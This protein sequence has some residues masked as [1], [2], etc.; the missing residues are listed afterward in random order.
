MADQDL[1]LGRDAGEVR[2][3]IIAIIAAVLAHVAL[4]TVT[5]I[6]GILSKAPEPGPI[7][8]ELE[9]GT[10][11]A[12]DRQGPIAA[13]GPA[14][15][16]AETIPEASTQVPRTGGGAAPAA[17][18]A[19][20]S[21][22]VI[23]TPK[24][25]DQTT[26]PSIS[27]PAFRTSGSSAAPPQSTTAPLVSQG[28]PTDVPALTAPPASQP[29]GGTGSTAVNAPARGVEVSGQS[30]TGGQLDLGS[31][32]SALQG[33]RSGAGGQGGSGS[34]GQSQGVAGQGGSGQ[35]GGGGGSGGTGASAIQWDT[36]SAARNRQPLYLPDPKIPAWVAKQGFTLRVTISFILSPEG[37]VSSANIE[38]SSGYGDVD[39]AV[40]EAV[41]FWRFT[42]DDAAAPLRGTRSFLFQL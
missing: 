38:R 15:A 11:P 25:A 36:P 32:D 7:F 23:P 27:G 10:L 42:A 6:A 18:R 5:M 24:G 22:F 2:R 35:T 13:A 33:A 9:S 12:G 21:D 28:S 1:V 4:V 31:L 40:L 16:S 29:S 3:H 19:P 14:A 20:S 39:A 8:L 37:V 41:R 30:R 26:Q 17:S 34:G